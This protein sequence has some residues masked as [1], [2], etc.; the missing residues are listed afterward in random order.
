MTPKNVCGAQLFPNKQ[1]PKWL[2]LWEF[3]L[4][5]EFPKTTFKETDNSGNLMLRKEKEI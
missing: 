3:P 5:Q 2:G 1:I 4:S